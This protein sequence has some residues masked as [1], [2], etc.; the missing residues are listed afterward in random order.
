MK[1]LQ[2]KKSVI[3]IIIHGILTSKIKFD[4]IPR[5]QIVMVI[6]TNNQP[7]KPKTYVD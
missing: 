3:A 7:T 1:S 4:N 5:D 2:N 6:T